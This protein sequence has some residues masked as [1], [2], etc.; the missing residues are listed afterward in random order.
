MEY[1]KPNKQRE[2]SLH[3]IEAIRTA[4]DRLVPINGFEN[5][6]VRDICHEANISSGTFYHHFKSKS[7]LMVDRSNRTYDYFNVLYNTKL[8]HMEPMDALRELIIEWN[9]YIKR[10]VLPVLKYYMHAVLDHPE[11]TRGVI[12]DM[13]R[14]QIEKGQAN[15]SIRNDYSSDDILKMLDVLT[16]GT[17]YCQCFFQGTLLEN[18]AV[19]KQMLDWLE[20]LKRN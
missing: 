5:M 2:Q 14:E 4:V 15:D 3:T 16:L 18:D 19:L 12:R 20:T 9:I 8:V 11:Y 1:L 13:C 7:E 10:R 6:T 17:S